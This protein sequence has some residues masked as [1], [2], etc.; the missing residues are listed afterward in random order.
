MNWMISFVIPAETGI[1][2]IKIV[3]WVMDTRFREYDDFYE[4][5]NYEVLSC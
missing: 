1:Q 3:T 5:V 4:V 2:F